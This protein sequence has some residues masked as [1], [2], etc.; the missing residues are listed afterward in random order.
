MDDFGKIPVEEIVAC[1][2]YVFCHTTPT[3]AV[4]PR[5]MS[6]R[7]LTMEHDVNIQEIVLAMRDNIPSHTM[8]HL[9]LWCDLSCLDSD[10]VAGLAELVVSVEVVWLWCKVTG[11]VCKAIVDRLE[12]DHVTLQTLGLYDISEVTSELL[13][14]LVVSVKEVELGYKVTG[15]VCE[16]IVGRLER[17]HATLQTLRLEDEMSIDDASG[18]TLAKFLD[19]DK[20]KIYSIIFATMNRTELATMVKMLGS[21]CTV[22]NQV[23]DCKKDELEINISKK[24]G[25]INIDLL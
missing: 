21:N 18:A 24:D 4:I 22:D 3:L 9:D 8:E 6:C 5:L 14:E 16:A 12:R 23:T 13:A 20:V 7:T 19:H 25:V 1:D 10:G 11:V 15:V 17:D 2:G